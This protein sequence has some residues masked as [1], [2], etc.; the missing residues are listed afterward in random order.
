M[1]D[2]IKEIFIKLFEIELNI[3]YS[4]KNDKRG[5]HYIKYDS[6]YILNIILDKFITGVCWRDIKLFK[7]NYLNTNHNVV[8]YM[9]VKLVKNNIIN[10]VYQKILNNFNHKIYYSHAYIDTTYILNKYGYNKFIKYNNYAITKHKTCKLSIIC[11]S[12]GIPLNVIIGDS[13]EHDIKMIFNTIPVIPAFNKLY[14]DKGYVSKDVK[15]QI[16]NKYNIDL[17][18]PPKKNQK[19]IILSPYDKKLLKID[20]LLNILIILLN[21][22]N[23]YKLDIL[24][25]MICF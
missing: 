15:K 1:K 21:K 9:Y 18:T 4:S 2:N 6:K 11:S 5:L 8:Y 24:K 23:K 19:N 14:G 22:I 3:F 17:I 7:S 20:L 16:K 10:N 13:L 12:N 25:K